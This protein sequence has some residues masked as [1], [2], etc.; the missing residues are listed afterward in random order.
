MALFSELSPSDQEN[1]S[2]GFAAASPGGCTPGLGR[3][4]ELATGPVSVAIEADQWVFQ[5]PTPALGTC[6][7]HSELLPCPLPLGAGPARPRG[8][9]VMKQRLGAWWP[10][11]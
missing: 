7:I 10:L 6:G 4:R 5:S 8:M 3:M 2:G 11:S 1:L 9:G